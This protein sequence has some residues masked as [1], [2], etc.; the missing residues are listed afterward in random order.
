M[1]KYDV[2]AYVWPAYTG[3]EIRTK[4]FWP[5]GN[6]EWE[7]VMDAKPKFPGHQWPRKPL[8]GYVNE[9][10]PDVMEMQINAAVEHGVNVFV[11]DW[12][13]FDGRP[14]LENC[15]NDGFLKA[16]NNE[17]MKF[18]LMWANHNVGYAW[19]RRISDIDIK[20]GYLCEKP[21]GEI[22]YTGAV[23]FERF[24]EIAHRM[25]DKY[26]SC[27]NYYKIDGKPVLMI[28]ALPMLIDGLGGLENTKKAL[29]WF[30][31]EAGG[32]HLQFN[33]DKVC[34]E[35]YDGDRLVPISELVEY[36]GFDSTTNYQTIGMVDDYERD[37]EDVLK[38][39]FEKWDLFEKKSAATY[40]PH[41]SVGW[42]NNPRFNDLTK[43][44]KNS[45]PEVFKNA[46]LKAKE[47]VDN[48]PENAPLITINSW[49]EWT[50]ASYLQPDDLYGYAYLDAV[51]SV[52]VD[53]E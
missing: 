45:T 39:S 40:F 25:I 8:W 53:E 24:K 18:Y 51:K 48:R 37:Y 19:D 46:L 34:E 33:M 50:E 2:A 28:F 26:F 12:Y 5:E 16:R 21:G 29:E 27:P 41:V 31:K 44:M 17:K 23:N 43:I 22:L 32:V 15:L 11:Y 20:G 42:D 10:N 38:D 35:I 14:F 52:F 9:A 49:N 30:K 36:L 3:E 6:G 4:I 7:T 13:Y 47:F 1:K